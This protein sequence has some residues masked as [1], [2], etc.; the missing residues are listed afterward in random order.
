MPEDLSSVIEIERTSF[1][2]PYPAWLF[3]ELLKENPNGFRIAVLNKEIVGYC[4]TSTD[5]RKEA[6]ILNSLAVVR[7]W[8]RQEIGKA[9]VKDAV[10]YVQSNLPQVKKIILQ[11]ALENRVAQSL[12]SSLGF[13]KSFTLKDY[14]GKNK[15]G[16]Q[17]ELV[18]PT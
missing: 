1:E 17:M 16:I 5:R 7:R 3:I 8:R 14:Y 12:Y 2:D 9:L 10:S 13:A 18:L 11:V 4:V 15:D 6:A